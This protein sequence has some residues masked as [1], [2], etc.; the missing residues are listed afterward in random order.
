MILP[1]EIVDKIL[2]F[3]SHPTADIM[4]AVIVKYHEVLIMRLKNCKCLH[5]SFFETW[6]NIELDQG[7]IDQM[8]K[9]LSQCSHENIDWDF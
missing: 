1:N 3:K 2:L 7:R 9:I 8:R 4:R 5:L 6:K